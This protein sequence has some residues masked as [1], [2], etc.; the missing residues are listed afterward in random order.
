MKRTK[1]VGAMAMAASG[2]AMLL[3][4]HAALAD[5]VAIAP[6]A[7]APAERA[8]LAD[9]IARARTAE[10]AAFAAVAD[11]RSKV[12][13]VDRK[14]RGRFMS[15]T[16]EF[17][18]LGRAALFPMLDMLAVNAA[19]RG[20]LSASAWR[21]LRV[22]LIE[23][24]G[25]LRDPRARPVLDAILHAP[26]SDPYVTAAAA[27]A[28]GRLGDDASAKEL[29]RLAFSPGPRELPVLRMVGECRRAV[30]AHALAD[31]LPK[32]TKPARERLMIHALSDV[33]NAWAWQ[34]PTLRKSTE[35][36]EVQ[37]T[38]A[39]ALV[40]EFV[41]VTGDMRLDAEEAIF[42]VDDPATPWLIQQAEGT[43]SP[44]QA[45]ALSDLARR[46]RH[47]PTR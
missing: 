25:M 24:V 2:A 41:R 40:D 44:A 14:K 20:P 7:L 36:A 18:T 21:G 26:V 33:G 34:T 23:A 22:S 19:P 42:V 35:R 9:S 47:N 32:Q 28:L 16:S 27:E 12:P 13:L 11:I 1:W 37:R 17:H 31:A 46:F 39:A 5:G 43:A 4:A 6:S 30:V 3:S 8:A 38:A 29:V 45:A 10:P 15:V